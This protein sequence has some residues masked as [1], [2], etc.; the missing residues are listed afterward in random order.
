MQTMRMTATKKKTRMTPTMTMTTRMMTP[1]TKM[2]MTTPTTMKMMTMMP[3]A[4]MAL[5]WVREAPQPAV[6]QGARAA[7][8]GAA[9]AFH[10]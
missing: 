2:R 1:T 5:V 9:R 8:A 4:A 3:A 6:A 10:A 7:V